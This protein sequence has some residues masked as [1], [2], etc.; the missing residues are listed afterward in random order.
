VRAVRF[1]PGHA[2]GFAARRVGVRA[3]HPDAHRTDAPVRV[4]PHATVDPALV[5]AHG[6]DVLGVR[7]LRIDLA[8]DHEVRVVRKR[9]EEIERRQPV[10]A[11]VDLADEGLAVVGARVTPGL[12]P[13]TVRNPSSLSASNSVVV[14]VL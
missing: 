5:V 7:K 9:V 11:G 13:L 6:Q 12:S 2:T 3:E 14:P 4:E 10:I 1:E 8:P